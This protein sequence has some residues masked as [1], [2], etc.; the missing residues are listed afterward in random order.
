VANLKTWGVADVTTPPPW[1][2]DEFHYKEVPAF[3]KHATGWTINNTQTVH[4]WIRKGIVAGNGEHKGQ[5][6]YL[7]SHSLARRVFVKRADVLAF[8]EQM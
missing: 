5:R 1:E 3:V 6:I 4:R 7:P 2:R 8:L